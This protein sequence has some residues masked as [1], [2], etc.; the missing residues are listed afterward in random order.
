MDKCY[1]WTKE[2]LLPKFVLQLN[3]IKGGRN[4]TVNMVNV[5]KE[6]SSVGRYKMGEIEKKYT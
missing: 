1:K 6:R 2:I 4:I 5:G 3:G